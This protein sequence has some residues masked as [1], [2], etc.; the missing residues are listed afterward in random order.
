I[1]VC[2]PG[3]LLDEGEV[4]LVATGV[5]Q[6]CTLCNGLWSR[7]KTISVYSSFYPG[8]PDSRESINSENYPAATLAT[9]QIFHF[10]CS[11]PVNPPQRPKERCFF[12]FLSSI[13]TRKAR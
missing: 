5:A 10:N 1:V 4:T 6:A 8:T 9:T 13:L 2:S 11:T 12:T 7:W 3:T